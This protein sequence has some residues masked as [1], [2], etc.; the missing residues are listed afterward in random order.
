[1]RQN[2]SDEMEIVTWGPGR[3]VLGIKRQW[4]AVCLSVKWEF[5][6]PTSASRKLPGG[7]EAVR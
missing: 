3:T 4:Q 7:E 6:A 2:I 5:A 1:M